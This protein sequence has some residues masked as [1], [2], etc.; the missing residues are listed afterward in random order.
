M[1]ILMTGATG[2]IGGRLVPLLV[3]QGHRVRC[4]AR[5]PARLTGRFAD[6]V[7]VV[8]GDV[9][10]ATSLQAAMQDM[11]VAY[12]LVH[13]MAAGEAGFQERDREAATVFAACAGAAG[14]QQIV[15]LG[16][17]G[18][19]GVAGGEAGLDGDASGPASDGAAAEPLSP[20]LRSRLEVGEVLR[21]GTVP[22]TEFRAAMIV[23]AGSISFEMLRYL[24]ERLPFMICPRWVETRSPPIAIGDVLAYLTAGLTQPAAR[25]KVYDIGGPDWI[26]YRTMMASYARLRHLRR[27]MIAVPVLTPRLSSYWVDLVTPIPAALARPLILGLRNELRCRPEASPAVDFPA[28]QPVGFETAVRQALDETLGNVVATAWSSALSSSPEGVRQKAQ[29]SEQDGL[30]MERREAVVAA[31]PAAVFRTVCSLGGDNS[32]FQYHWLWELRGL[33]DRLCGGVGMRRGRRHRH[34]LRVGDPVD[35]WRVEALEPD[36]LLRLRAE[37]KLPGNAWL[38]FEVKAQ[39]DGTTHLIQ[40]AL[41]EPHGLL[42]LLYWWAVY[43]LHGPVFSGLIAGLAERATAGCARTQGVAVANTRPALAA[44]RTWLLALGV[45]A[46]GVA[47]GVAVMG[48]RLNRRSR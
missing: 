13:S 37:M 27:W 29:L 26:S 5:D 25:G 6:S 14:L 8:Q 7:E 36:R 30:L 35:F 16:G 21:A 20:H 47:L 33:L 18:D 39:G 1:N 28:I 38:Q 42:G 45:V 15:Y 11:H 44:R 32:W 22:V 24:V 41:Y 48:V 31:T 23:G 19:A 9:R 17:L 34:E 12:Y 43:P 2:Y 40:T 10:D 46:L 4:L 3:E